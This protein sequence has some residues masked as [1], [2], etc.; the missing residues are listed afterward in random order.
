MVNWKWRG[1]QRCPINLKN[2]QSGARRRKSGNK[3]LWKKLEIYLE[4]YYLKGSQ[5][6]MTYQLSST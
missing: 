2:Y 4:I 5:E 1:N 6:Q 3:F